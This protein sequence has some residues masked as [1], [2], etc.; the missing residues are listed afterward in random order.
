ME[1]VAKQKY[2][3]LDK[4]WRK[5]PIKPEECKIYMQLLYLE[6]CDENNIMGNLPMISKKV[7]DQRGVNE[8]T[9]LLATL[10]GSEIKKFKARASAPVGY[11]KL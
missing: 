5:Q 9:S 10:Y 6:D 3:P 11:K 1:R 8:A 4:L 7:F 2:E